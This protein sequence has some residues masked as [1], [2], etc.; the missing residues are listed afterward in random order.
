MAKFIA[1]IK[2]MVKRKL[3]ARLGKEDL[4]PLEVSDYI[5]KHCGC[6]PPGLDYFIPSRR[7]LRGLLENQI[8]A[9]PPEQ[10]VG[11]EA[12]RFHQGE[13]SAPDEF[14]VREF[15]YI[16]SKRV[17]LLQT[18]L[19]AALPSLSLLEIGDS[20]GL[21]V[22]ALGKCGI[23]VNISPGAVKNIHAHGIQAVQSDIEHLPF[24]RKSVDVVMMFETLEHLPNPL[25]ALCRAAELSREKVII[26]IPYV[27]KSR[28]LPAGY[29]KGIPQYRQHI[30]ELNEKDFRSIVSHAPLRI[31]RTASIDV[32]GRPRTFAQ[33]RLYWYCDHLDVW[34]GVVR[35]QA[36][37]ELEVL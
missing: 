5:E 4:T 27:R 36:Y 31:G 2:E 6:I 14:S 16:Y 3:Q 20:D 1:D 24:H 9:V 32:F 22:K 12:I 25:A 28:I 19:G 8:A 23:G 30:F 37:Y 7:V 11:D 15:S 26:S 10:W 29:R 33:R 18:W 35:R 13:E 21:I 17:A 34:G